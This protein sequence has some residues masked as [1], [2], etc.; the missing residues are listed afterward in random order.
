ME[1]HHIYWWNLENLFDVQNSPQRPAWLQKELD[2]ELVGWDLQVLNRKIDNLVSIISKF[3][4]G[5]GADI[6]GVC[7]VENE[8]V[9]KLLTTAITAKTG[10][11]YEVVHHD[12]NDQ[13]GIDIA[14]FY[15]ISKYTPIGKLFSLEIMK[16]N[17]TR[18]VIQMTFKTNQNNEFTLLGNH[19]PSRLGG[20][21]ESEPYRI[22]AAET[23][24]YWIERIHEIKGQ[25]HPVILMG[26]F[27][28]EP[29]DRAM[30]EY[31]L[32]THT[33]QK[34][35]NA[36]NHFLLN[37]M[38]EHLGKNF[39][40]HVYGNEVSILDQFLVSKSVASNSANYPFKVD[41]SEIISYPELIK[42]DYNTPI[43]FGRPS[44]SDYNPAGFSDHLPIKLVLQEK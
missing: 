39:G 32:G 40:T 6:M 27:N 43:R 26:D 38:Y 12:T 30:T 33:K 35:L 10:K 29:F 2:K 15:D 7:E 34:V 42:G 5:Q 25:D 23:V 4:D 22:M 18:D 9:M 36:K 41:S 1:K 24:A 3:N 19:F 37:I 28:D 17:A 44:S 11:T 8:N 13:R 16:R 21:Y 14:F 20:K 31:L